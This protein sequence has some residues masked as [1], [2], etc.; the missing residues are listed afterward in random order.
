M[1][2]ISIL[3]DAKWLSRNDSTGEL[4]LHFQIKLPIYTRKIHNQMAVEFT[5]NKKISWK[6]LRGDQYTADGS[7]ELIPLEGGTKT[8][9]ILRN[10]Y[11]FSSMGTIADYVLKS[12]PDAPVAVKSILSSVWMRA[13]RDWAE[14]PAP[15]KEKLKT[16]KKKKRLEEIR[17]LAEARLKK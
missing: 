16:L 17:R 10:R 9:G 13:V 4:D 12:I 7:W 14:T 3:D 1:G 8:L 6:H 5:P 15:D 2:Y 11:S